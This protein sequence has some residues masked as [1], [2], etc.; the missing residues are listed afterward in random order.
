MIVFFRRPRLSSTGE[1]DYEQ[2]CASDNEI[3]SSSSNNEE[4][5]DHM[6][7]MAARERLQ[8]FPGRVPPRKKKRKVCFYSLCFIQILFSNSP[9]NNILP[10]SNILYISIGIV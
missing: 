7:Y 4:Q 5:N 8:M 6:N 1:D 9:L 3:S 2:Q 10:Y